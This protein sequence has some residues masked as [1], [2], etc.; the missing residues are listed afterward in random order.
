VQKNGASLTKQGVDIVEI[1]QAERPLHAKNIS[2]G[3]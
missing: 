1:K 2:T 3:I